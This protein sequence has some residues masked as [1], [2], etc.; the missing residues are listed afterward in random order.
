MVYRWKGREE[1]GIIRRY[2]ER[3]IGTWKVEKEWC[4][5]GRVESVQ[6]RKGL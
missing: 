6:R 1:E 5:G 2:D 3:E 4:T